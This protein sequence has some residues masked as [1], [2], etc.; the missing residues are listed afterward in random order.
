[1]DDLESKNRVA[2]L[3]IRGAPYFV[4]N[5][6]CSQGCAGTPRVAFSDGSHCMESGMVKKRDGEDQGGQAIAQG[7]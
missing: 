2:S 4:F 5:K 3:I 1:M 6:S 7:P